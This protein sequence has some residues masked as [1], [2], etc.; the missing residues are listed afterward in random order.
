MGMVVEGPTGGFPPKGTGAA[1]DQQE[2]PTLD[3]GPDRPVVEPRPLEIQCHRTFV[4][5]V[6]EGV[7]SNLTWAQSLVRVTESHRLIRDRPAPVRHRGQ[8]RGPQSRSVYGVD[9]LSLV[10]RRRH[11]YRPV[12]CGR[13]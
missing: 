10:F 11:H 3:E 2:H 9:F 8:G 7:D 6:V 13:G 5:C 4:A 12:R 1:P